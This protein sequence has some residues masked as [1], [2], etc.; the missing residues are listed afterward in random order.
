MKCGGHDGKSNPVGLTI[1][2]LAEFSGIS[3]VRYAWTITD[4]G[5]QGKNIDCLVG[6][7]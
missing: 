1:V 2:L 5:T 6:R 3:K 7:D 4:L